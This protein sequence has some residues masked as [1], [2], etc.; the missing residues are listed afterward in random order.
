MKTNLI[1]V[2]VPVYN[3]EKFLERCVC[4]ITNQTHKNLEILLIDD[5]STDGSPAICDSLAKTDN[6]IKVVHQPNGGVS[7]ARNK[8]LELATGKYVCFVDSDDELLNNHFEILVNDLVQQG[9]EL[10][11]SPIIR[12]EKEKEDVLYSLNNPQ[13]IN[14]N[15]V[16]DI[17]HLILNTSWKGPCNKIYIKEKITSFFPLEVH[18][19]EDAIFNL[20]YILNI[21][22]IY[23]NTTATYKYFKNEHSLTS[24]SRKNV[25]E[26][27]AIMID[28]LYPILLK[29]THDQKTAATLATREFIPNL[30]YTISDLILLKTKNKQIKN[31]LVNL[32]NNNH[33]K[34]YLSIL[35]CNG[36]KEKIT[37]FMFKNKWFSLLIFI[38]KINLLLKK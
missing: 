14:T 10:V 5:G 30:S 23:L 16:D 4:S 20:N 13:I 2:I 26:K 37:Y 28:H 38:H 24:S 15:N 17:K 34:K 7:S 25:C 21:S 35:S 9:A 8:G 31:F 32:F 12:V 27:I 36:I 3:A 11:I 33:V 18:L 19:G 29:L 22:K 6:R 1:T